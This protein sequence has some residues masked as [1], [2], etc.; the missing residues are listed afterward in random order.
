[1]LVRQIKLKLSKSEVG[2]LHYWLWTLTG[3]Y[4]WAIRKIE[5]DAKNKIYHSA[6]SRL[7]V[8]VAI[9]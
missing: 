1:M 7:L 5:L 8:T 2:K 3:V 9:N 4:N 6:L